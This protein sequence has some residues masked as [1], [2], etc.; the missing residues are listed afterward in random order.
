MPLLLEDGD[1]DAVAVARVL[2]DEQQVGL[3]GSAGFGHRIGRSIALAYVARS[4]SLPGTR[5]DVEVLGERRAAVVG[6]EPLFDPQNLRL[7]G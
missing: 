5:L 3:V 7:R 4:H 1:T 6:S 2:A